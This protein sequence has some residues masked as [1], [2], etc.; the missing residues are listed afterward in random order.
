ME[1]LVKE[2]TTLHK[3]LNK[4]LG[5]STVHSIMGQVLDATNT[6]LAEEYNKVEFKSEDA[7]KRWVRAYLMVGR[8]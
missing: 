7:K 2:I 8:I 4:Y 6:K 5:L 3:V 1:Q